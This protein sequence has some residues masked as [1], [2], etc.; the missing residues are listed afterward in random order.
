MTILNK[1]MQTVKEFDSIIRAAKEEFEAAKEQIFATYKDPAATE[2]MAEAR[3]ILTEIEIRETEKARVAVREDFAAAR[4]KVLSFVSE[5]VPATFSETLE[6]IRAKGEKIT[7]YEAKSYLA[8]YSENYTAFSAL[9]N[10]LNGLGKAG[11]VYILTPDHV[12]EDVAAMEKRILHWIQNRASGGFDSEY[13]SRLFTKE[14][15]GNPIQLLADRI[16][17]FISGKFILDNSEA[18]SVREVN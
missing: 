7:D 18:E 9:L 12:D 13:Y 17:A 3:K 8:K 5:S 10:V 16:E 15:G 2:R 6:A 11:G 1:T 4:D 14:N